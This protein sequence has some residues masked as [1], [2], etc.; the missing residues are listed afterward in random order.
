M[1]IVIVVIVV[2]IVIVRSSSISNNVIRVG[3]SHQ[4]LGWLCCQAL[5][6]V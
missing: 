2:V 3:S 6:A 5:T 4:K 1:H